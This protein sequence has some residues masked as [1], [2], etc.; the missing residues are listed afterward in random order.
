M[1]HHH[2]PMLLL[3]CPPSAGWDC[4]MAMSL[5]LC[6]LPCPTC[7]FKRTFLCMK[8]FLVLPAY[9]LLSCLSVAF[10][11]Y[12]TFLSLSL[13][14]GSL[15]LLLLS[16]GSRQKR[17]A[18]WLAGWL[19]L[20]KGWATH[21]AG[22]QEDGRRKEGRRRRRAGELGQPSCAPALQHTTYSSLSILSLSLLLSLPCYILYSQTLCL[23]TT[24]LILP[25][26]LP[27]GSQ[28]SPIL[29]FSISLSLLWEEQI[30]G[31]LSFWFD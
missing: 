31:L 20:G 16:A 8:A 27:L 15:C 11:V 14:E 18:G 13:P 17:Q 28:H 1:C 6:Y 25:P 4:C 26:I 21:V 24:T 30:P 12:V 7:H 23:Y 10:P 19:V 3:V 5:C 9:E 22:R 29:L 2:M